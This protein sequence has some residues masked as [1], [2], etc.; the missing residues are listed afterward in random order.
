MAESG[1]R[2]TDEPASTKERTLARRRSEKVGSQEG[3]IECRKAE[4][5]MI[6]T[7]YKAKL[8]KHLSYPVGAEALTEGLAG[9][10]H[11]EALSVSFWGTPVWPG[12]RFQKALAENQP[13]MVLAARHE[14]TRKPGYGGAQDLVDG[15]WYEE[16]WELT[17]YP[18]VRELRHL[19]S[20]ALK[21]QG[22]PLIAEWLRSSQ[23]AGWVIRQQRL[24]LVFNPTEGTIRA[25][26]VSGV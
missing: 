22:L 4:L 3:Q 21:E 26:K 16:K 1:E 8:P 13:Y 19:A 10:P 23:Q 17:V 15:G 7:T 2:R 14:P 20:Q 25:Q 12:S 5:A 6:P 11:I 18:V 24:E 9:A